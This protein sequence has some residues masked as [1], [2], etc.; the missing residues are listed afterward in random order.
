MRRSF[1]AICLL[2]AV[3]PACQPAA[4]PPPPPLSFADYSPIHLEV[5]SIDVVEEYRSPLQ[6]PNVEHLFPTS[7]A[8]AVHIWVR[9]RLRAVGGG[10]TLQVIVKDASVTEEPLPRT[11]GLKGTFTNDQSERYA[12][13]LE[14]EMRIYGEQ[15][16]MSEASINVVATRTDTAAE[17][18]SLSAREA[19]FERMVRDLMSIL[20]AEIEKNLQQY[21]SNYIRYAPSP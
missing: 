11:P 12:A 3:L 7:P 14:V 16:A 20:N 10:R 4:P 9:D 17:D 21:F 19:L 18:F 1:L 15:G 5:A 8:E 13:R 2:L 6:R